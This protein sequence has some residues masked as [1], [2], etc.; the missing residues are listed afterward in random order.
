M[1]FNSFV[2]NTN[3]F[4][5]ILNSLSKILPEYII[6]NIDK[7]GL[8]I[9]NKEKLVISDLDISKEEFI[10]FFLKEN[11]TLKLSL[12]DLLKVIKFIKKTDT[13][14]IEIND[15]CSIN[16]LIHNFNDVVKINPIPIKLLSKSDSNI[17]TKD[18]GCEFEIEKQL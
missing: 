8:R 13:L 2:K 6:I 18:Y 4:V 16:F 1:L 12:I 11:L 10:N 5:N 9:I 7:F 3:R 14:Q 17:Y 15:K